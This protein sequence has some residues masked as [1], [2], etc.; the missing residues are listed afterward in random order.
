MRKEEKIAMTMFL[1][2]TLLLGIFY[3]NDFG[4]ITG[5][6]VSEA[7]KRGKIFGTYSV[8]PSF[9]VNVDYDL[10]DYNK[11]KEL[12]VPILECQKV[13]SNFNECIEEAE[14][15]DDSFEWSLNCDK[16]VEKALHD[17]AEFYQD[18]MNSDDTNCLCKKDLKLPKD[19]LD[20]FELAGKK[21]EIFLTEDKLNKRINIKMSDPSV[22][23]S[24]S[25][26]NNE[27]SG[28][29]PERYIIAY[30]NDKF[31]RLNMIF[32][33]E[34]SGNTHSLGPLNEIIIF[35]NERDERQYADFVK[36]DGD[37]LVYPVSERNLKIPANLHDCSLK[38]RNIHRICVTKKDSKL[39]VSD[40]S[41]NEVKPRDIVYKFGIELPKLPPKPIDSLEIKDALKAENSVILIWDKGDDSDIESYSIYSSTDD[42]ID[43][44]IEEIKADGNIDETTVLNEEPE[45]IE[46]INLEECI[47]DTIG[48]KC[49]YSLYDNPLEP[50]KLYYWKAQDK[51][52]YL[53]GNLK[54]GVEHNFALTAVNG[55]GTE[56]NNDKSIEDNTYILTLDNN[57]VR[58]A[59]RDDLAPD[60][61]ENLKQQ[62]DSDGKIKLVWDKPLKNIDGSAS[63][64]VASFK[65]YYKKSTL[66]LS[67]ALDV[68]PGIKP[69]TTADANCG[70]TVT[71]SC[72]YSTGS[73]TSLEKG[74]NYNF[75]VTALDENSNKFSANAEYVP[76]VIT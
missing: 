4:G 1:F 52:I 61:V 45:E 17:F 22:D 6:A 36:Q 63:I 16:D 32:R 31:Y 66:T 29:F 68:S 64:D 65:I 33:D 51:F 42:F 71:L 9:K 41:E 27:I 54:D 70:S 59:P 12:L 47:I 67:P 15:R 26:N 75:A 55:E 11:I 53:I 35:K 5:A 24:Y 76:V 46:D 40:K 3:F 62:I 48:T 10:D 60:K 74:K 37:T 56:I 34:F 7:E 25:I 44:K 14:S 58:F 72:E 13:R 18:C 49:K 28:W 73:I 20:K 50:N 19:D 30:T 8:K 57:Y 21:Y 39:V 43:K 69:I 38:S 2:I 23:L